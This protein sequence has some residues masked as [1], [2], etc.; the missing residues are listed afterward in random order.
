MEG[1]V[2][3]TAEVRYVTEDSA[4]SANLGQ[5]A[6]TG[7]IWTAVQ[8]W[9][10]RITG[11]ITIAVLTRTLA[12][13]D[14]GTVAVVT[15]ILPIAY[16]LADMGFSIYVVQAP[17][18]RSRTLST[19]FWFS[20]LAGIGL[21]GGLIILAPV[22]AWAF[23]VP[24]AVPVIRGLSTAVLCVTFGAVPTSLLKRRMEFRLLAIQSVIASLI[25]QAV[26]VGLAL[27]GYGVW[28]L[29]AQ[30]V[31]FQLVASTLA[32]VSAGWRPSLAFSTS[33]FHT[34]ASFGLKVAGVDLV[35]LLRG[36]VENAILAATLGVTG[37]GYV[38]VAQRL[39][40]ITQDVTAAAALPVSTVVFSQIRDDAARLRSNYRRALGL[41]Y[42][43]IV[44][45][46]VFLPASAPSLIP[47]LFGR[48][49][50]PSVA[51][52]RILAVV[53]ILVLGAML[54]H[55]L[56]YGVGAPGRWFVYGLAVDALT[57]VAALA[58]APHG[59]VAWSLGFL[60]V[61]LIATAARWPIVGRLVD[62]P[63]YMAAITFAKAC[64]SGI[65]TAIAGFGAAWLTSTL[66]NIVAILIIGVV[67]VLAHL[68]SMRFLMRMELQD[69][70]ELARPRLTGLMNRS[71]SAA[72]EGGTHVLD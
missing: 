51:P 50:G 47:F 5:R 1:A 56:F 62:A 61:A 6:L 55:G 18:V 46:M 59:T 43:V 23:H 49:W 33:E 22:L 4:A 39:M 16:L 20:A 27:F 54:D 70:I 28:A 42:A 14:F 13:A 25:G 60:A 67:V 65:I 58:C 3:P 29:V 21:T 10:T 34:M 72:M 38:N 32:W 12:P 7:V 19:A 63:W 48:Q 30:A 11:F 57:V 15:A 52:S 37:L 36:W 35:A 24:D 2:S 71:R 26:A 68:L 31:L 45:V 66:S 53:G 17:D 69:L 9:A 44:P 40:Q 64:G 41:C 8:K